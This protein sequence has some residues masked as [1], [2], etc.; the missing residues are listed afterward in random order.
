MARAREV[1]CGPKGR[2]L[3]MDTITLAMPE[4]A[5]AFVVCGSHGGE[6]AAGFAAGKGLAGAFFNDAG[7]GKD[8]AG[9]SGLDLL[10]REGVA[11][12]TVAH[13]SARIGDATDTWE[14]GVV[15]HLNAQA[16]ALGLKE[17]AALRPQL[18][19]LIGVA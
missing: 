10:E 2:V 8:R 6:T 7:V 19:R 16:R 17:G 15:S 14:A 9:I 3:A 18:L 12:G 13:T 5:G 11:A 4:D 1:A